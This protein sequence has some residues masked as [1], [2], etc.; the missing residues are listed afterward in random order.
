ML[1]PILV[2]V[3]RMNALEMD[4]YEIEHEIKFAP[5]ITHNMKIKIT[6]EVLE[7]SKRS[8]ISV[9]VKNK[10]YKGI[11]IHDL[12]LILSVLRKNGFYPYWIQ[13]KN[14]YLEIKADR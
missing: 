14:G 5:T 4:M 3:K 2:Q 10:L 9:K 1:N 8:V 6:G 7:I 11:T 12:E 13:T